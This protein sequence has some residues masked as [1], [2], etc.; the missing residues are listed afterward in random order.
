[1]RLAKVNR[2]SDAEIVAAALSDPDT[3]LLT[4]EDLARAVIVIPPPK[5]AIAL[6]VDQDVLAFYRSGGRGYQTRMNAALRAVMTARQG[7]AKTASHSKTRTS[8]Q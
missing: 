1:M 2:M 5:K 7:A 3:F 8:R 4:D 6:R